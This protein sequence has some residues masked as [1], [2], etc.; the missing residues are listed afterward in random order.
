MVIYISGKIGDKGVTDAVR[1]KF[2]RAEDFLKKRGFTVINPTDEVINK[3]I[4][5]AAEAHLEVRQKLSQFR[6]IEC[7]SDIYDCI[8]MED[9][10]IISMCDAVYMLEDYK[11]SP[12]AMA[13][14]EY[15]KATKKQIL[16]QRESDAYLHI[17]WVFERMVMTGQPPREYFRNPR[18][19]ATFEFVHNHLSEYYLPIV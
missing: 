17:A 4:V 15:A 8:L 6:G 3:K 9:M 12:G 19:I 7:R 1:R 18:N 14:Y 13:E 2:R 16:L 5:I 10:G 11:Y